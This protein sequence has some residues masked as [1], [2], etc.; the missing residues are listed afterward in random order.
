MYKCFFI[1][2]YMVALN[3]VEEG[4]LYFR[5]VYKMS[6]YARVWIRYQYIWQQEENLEIN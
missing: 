4:T 1:R 3:V 5:V 2:Y 6:S